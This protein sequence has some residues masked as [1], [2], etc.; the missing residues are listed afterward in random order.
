MDSRVDTS[1]MI[2]GD[3]NSLAAVRINQEP[4][5]GCPIRISP[6]Q[7]SF[8]APRR[9]SQRITSF[10]A[11]ACQGIHQMP[12]TFLISPIAHARSC[13]V[14]RAFGSRRTLGCAGAPHQRRRPVGLADLS[15]RS[16]AARSN[17]ERGTWLMRHSLDGCRK[18]R[19]GVQPGIGV[20]QQH[21]AS[22]RGRP[23]R[24]GNWRKTSFS[25][26][27]PAA[28]G[29]AKPITTRGHPSRRPKPVGCGPPGGS[30]R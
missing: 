2:P 29:Q 10:I 16:A 6:D 7:S 3:P 13:P 25:R 8:A 27:N 20:L 14:A 1:L 15:V 4:E 18:H 28:C 19:A 30:R 12:L 5:V 26:R 24:A 17:K 22:S 11:C 21:P 23:E 9:F